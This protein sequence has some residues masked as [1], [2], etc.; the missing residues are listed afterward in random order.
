MCLNPIIANP[1]YDLKVAVYMIVSSSEYG[2]LRCG[3]CKRTQCHVIQPQIRKKIDIETNE[4]L[5]NE[6]QT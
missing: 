6:G 2:L 1:N 5:T 4:M 3:P